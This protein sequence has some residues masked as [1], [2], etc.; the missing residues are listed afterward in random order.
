[1]LVGQADATLQLKGTMAQLQGSAMTQ[2]SGGIT[3]IG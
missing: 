2:I 3:M 1:M